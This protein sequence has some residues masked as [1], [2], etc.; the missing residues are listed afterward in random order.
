MCSVLWRNKTTKRL[1]RHVFNSKVC[2]HFCTY[3]YTA[4]NVY[5]LVSG[6]SQTAVLES[7]GRKN[8][9][10]KSKCGDF[11]VCKIHIFL[12]S[13]YLKTNQSSRLVWPSRLCCPLPYFGRTPYITWTIEFCIIFSC[14]LIACCPCKL[15]ELIVYC[16]CKLP[17][18]IARCPCKVPE[19][20]ACC[21]CKLPELIACCPCKFPVRIFG[22]ETVAAEC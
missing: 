1:W 21:P 17:E 16:P 11:S 10:R 14:E 15:P 8:L 4:S 18:L 22:G 2:K 3:H 19:L 7:E 12:L 9:C 20:I 5:S 13:Q 6:Y